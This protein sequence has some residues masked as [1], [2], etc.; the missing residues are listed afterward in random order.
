MRP[1]NMGSSVFFH[2]HLI[3][4][5]KKRHRFENDRLESIETDD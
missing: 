3:F 5:L 1:V 4:F 2:N